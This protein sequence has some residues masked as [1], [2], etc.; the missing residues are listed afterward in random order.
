MTARRRLRVRAPVA[1]HAPPSRVERAIA[2]MLVAA[3]VLAYVIA[4]VV[5][6]L[7]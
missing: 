7:P 2:V 3:I 1:D 4:D 5:G 6:A